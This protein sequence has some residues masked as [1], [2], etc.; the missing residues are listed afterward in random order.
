MGVA[1][2]R[3]RERER[4]RQEILAAA[5]EV[6]AER[7][8]AGASMGAIAGRAELGKATLYYYFETKEELHAAVLAEGTE[9]FFA[10]LCAV[11]TGYASLADLLEAVLT[12]YVGFF[13]EH[14]ALL[15][16]TA[17]YLTHI[18]WG[19]TETAPS[20]SQPPTH[21]ARMPAHAS[22]VAEL[23]RLLASSPFAGREAVFMGFLA[24]LFVTLT[25]RLATDG[26][27]DDARAFYVDLLRRYGR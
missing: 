20:G 12:A 17:P 10:S 2:R 1:Q 19:H 8:L 5:A 9:R 7:G 4:R 6:F 14:G 25:R 3:E 24:D 23:R 26:D 13:A 11:E 27:V 21:G 16:V 22:F 15:Q 18:H